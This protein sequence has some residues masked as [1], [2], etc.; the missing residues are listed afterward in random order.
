MT[1]GSFEQ[2]DTCAVERKSEQWEGVF[3]T[4]WYEYGNTDH[5]H[6]MDEQLLLPRPL[7]AGISC[8]SRPAELPWSKA[9]FLVFF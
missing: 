5:G 8:L 2:L 7:L 3:C 6:T 1:S 4:S 9:G